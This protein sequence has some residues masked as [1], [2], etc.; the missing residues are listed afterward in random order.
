MFFFQIVDFV[1]FETALAVKAGKSGIG[2]TKRTNGI[3]IIA[4]TLLEFHSKFSRFPS[5]ATREQDIDEL[6]K[7]QNEV[8]DRLGLD[9]N[10]LKNCSN[11]FKHVFGQ[12][13]PVCAV[14]GGV[15]GQDVIRSLSR[16]DA[17]IRNFFLFNGLNYTGVIE[18]IGK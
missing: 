5:T 17:P 3:L 12:L 7:L 18:S 14:V 8:L 1:P 11:W 6:F 10:V 4:H 9:D 2:L 16:N 13:S 15:I